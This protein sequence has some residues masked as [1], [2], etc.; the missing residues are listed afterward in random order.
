[1]DWNDLKRAANDPMVQGAVCAIAIQ[2]VILGVTLI[3]YQR[4][5]A[6]MRVTLPNSHMKDLLAGEPVFFSNRQLGELALIRVPI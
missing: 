2:T 6:N 3:T 5:G 4:L 1:M